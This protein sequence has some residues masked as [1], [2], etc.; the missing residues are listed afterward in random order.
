MAKPQ[1][2]RD[3]A[4]NPAYAVLPWDEYRALDPSISDNALTDEE[5][6]FRAEAE[7]TEGFPLE[8]AQ[9]LAAGEN[10]VRVYR[11]HRE[12]T[13]KELAA[14]TGLH[15]VYIS[16]VETGKRRGRARTIALIA[17]ALNVDIDD[18]IPV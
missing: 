1:I 11:R 6:A 4:G 5:L 13:Q 18:L 14:R 15:P 3:A 7:F 9:R 16:Q 2:I 10:P 17:N 8:V 12:L